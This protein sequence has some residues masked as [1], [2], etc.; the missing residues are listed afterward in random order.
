MEAFLSGIMDENAIPDDLTDK[1]CCMYAPEGTYA[2][3]SINC[4]YYQ[5][6]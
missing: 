3:L 6:I 2:S 5:S 4:P 1:E